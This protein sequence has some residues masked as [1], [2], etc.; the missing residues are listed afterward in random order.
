MSGKKQTPEH[1]KGVDRDHLLFYDK[2]WTSNPDALYLHNQG[3]LI[4]PLDREVHEAKHNAIAFIPTL[5]RC[6]LS[7]V[8]REF[9]PINGDYVAS[10]DELIMTINRATKRCNVR[11]DERH[12]AEY[13]I[14]AL[15]RERPFV[16]EGLVLPD[17]TIRDL[18]G[19]ALSS[20][21]KIKID[22]YAG[23]LD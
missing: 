16:V 11:P 10:L 7:I 20:S 21:N 13:T 17:K 19:R 3:M 22:R 4:A 12:Y 14:D 1:P 2:E 5:G 8:A 6:V 23:V 15:E 18:G 9:R